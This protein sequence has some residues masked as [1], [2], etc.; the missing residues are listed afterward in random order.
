V[1]WNWRLVIV[2]VVAYLVFLIMD[3]PA[4]VVKD[5]AAGAES[6]L[7]LHGVEGSVWDG[8]A[9]QIDYKGVGFG[10]TRW[11]ARPAAL[12]L[13]RLEYQLDFQD[14][15][16]TGGG[17]F[18]RSLT[19]RLY[20]HDLDAR[21]EMQK[22]NPLLDDA[23]SVR[24]AGS[25]R[26]EMQDVGVEQG[27]LRD[28]AGVARWERAALSAPLDLDMGFVELRLE[29][30]DEG[31]QW[32]LSGREESMRSAGVASMTRDDKDHVLVLLTPTG[33]WPPDVRNALEGVGG[34]PQKGG[35]FRIDLTDML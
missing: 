1:N 28:A 6:G 8:R 34:T 30:G 3:T 18:G 11:Q 31:V 33:T 27:L 13:G 20:A 10:A 29:P 5:L 23:F 2:G 24:V 15:Q 17:T 12:L 25:L 26:L 4:R 9:A 22:F 14:A 7:A 21:V 35:G 16:G 19:G 32:Q